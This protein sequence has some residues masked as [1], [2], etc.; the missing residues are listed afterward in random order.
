MGKNMKKQQ[1]KQQSS[2]AQKIFKVATSSSGK[3]SKQKKA[4]EVPKKLKQ[5]DLKTKSKADSQ[6]KN[7]HLQMVS[8]KEKKEQ[9]AVGRKKEPAPSTQKVEDTLD[10]MNVN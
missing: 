7:L 2:K 10:K 1:Q 8:K 4:K 3:K 5:L 6:L 9:K